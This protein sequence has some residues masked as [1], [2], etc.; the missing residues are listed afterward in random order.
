VVVLISPAVVQ[1]GP[2]TA[3]WWVSHG[4]EVAGKASGCDRGGMQC[5][6][7]VVMW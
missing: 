5:S 1:K 7:L 2:T 3:R 4:G 6:V